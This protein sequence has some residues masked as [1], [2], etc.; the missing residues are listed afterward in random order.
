MARHKEWAKAANGPDWTDV[1]MAM[2]ALEQVHDCRVGLTVIPASNGHNGGGKVE[3][4]ADFAT[5]TGNSTVRRE[6]VHFTWPSARGFGLV[7][8]AYR[9]IL[10]LDYKIGSTYKQQKLPE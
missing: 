3:V 5:L 6:S 2:T 10:E 8:A 4:W 7:G 1:L 9:A